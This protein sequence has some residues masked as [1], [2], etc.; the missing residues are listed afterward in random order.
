MGIAEAKALGFREG[1][2]PAPGSPGPTFST[3]VPQ[4]VPAEAAQEEEGLPVGHGLVP[5]LG[6]EALPQA[7]ALPECHQ[8]D[9]VSPEAADGAAVQQQL[10]G[11]HV[12][13]HLQQ[14]VLGQ[15]VDADQGHGGGGEGGGA[16][17][18][19]GGNTGYEP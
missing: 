9:E 7:L 17:R 13:E 11:G 14:N 4:E 18:P 19:V 16:H 10:A 15:L 12:R 5:V 6:D 8:V 1:R 2:E 3:R